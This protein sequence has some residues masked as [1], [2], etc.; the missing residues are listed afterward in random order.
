MGWIIS[1]IILAIIA[2]PILYYLWRH[3][4]AQKPW[5]PIYALAGFILF[6]VLFYAFGL[7]PDNHPTDLDVEAFAEL[8]VQY[9]GRLMPVDTAA[10][11]SLRLL[12]GR[13][14]VE[15]PS[16]E[17]L[18]AIDWLLWTM[19]RPADAAELRVFR[20]DHPEVKSLFDLSE[21]RKYFSYAELVPGLEGIDKVI[22]ELPPD[23]ND[24]S[25]YQQQLVKT[26][27]AIELYNNLSSSFHPGINR[28]DIN[29]IDLVKLYQN[30]DDVLRVAARVLSA[31]NSGE[32]P[33]PRD[34]RFLQILRS[35]VPVFQVMASPRERIA[36]V[37]PADPEADLDHGTYSDAP[38]QTMGA[39]LLEAAQTARTH[40]TVSDYADLIL[41]YRDS[42]PEAFRASVESI[43]TTT[44]DFVSTRRIALEEGFNRSAPFFSGSIIYLACLL[45]IFASWLSIN[46]KAGLPEALRQTAFFLLIGGFLLHSGG[47]MARMIIMERPAPVT[48]LYSSAV[49][50]GWAACGLGLLLEQIYRNSFGVLIAGV[51]GFCTLIIAH[52]LGGS[53][54]TMEAMRAV[55]DSNFWLAT[56]V[57][58]ITLGYTPM[59]IAALLA[60]VF[61]LRG[62]FTRGFSAAA[63]RSIIQ[64]I[65]GTIGFALI[66]SFIGTF[67]GGVWADQSWGRFW[68][69]DPKENGALMI[70]LWAALILHA[71]I[72]GVARERGLMVLTLFG[73]MITAW[74][75]F[76]TNQLGIGLHSYGFT[77]AGHFWLLVFWGS[78]LLLIGLALVPVR[79][80][81]SQ[82]IFN[83]S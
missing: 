41:A 83:H 62:L 20:I 11:T 14:T 19:A 32:S 49:F 30:W 17:R 55:L 37:P 64:M 43:Q 54:D 42:D 33:D 79:F 21:E 16:G 58:T 46:E 13:E 59:F 80:W 51:V 10:R 57:V 44:S 12:R 26:L 1:Y 34:A 36:V 65:Y 61:I 70:V 27:T 60:I 45:L 71:R 5:R 35:V 23:P 66:L 18:F 4:V 82:Q 68:G 3:P 72:A 76:G 15:A 73:S 63:S 2:L 69:W 67:L 25:V 39:A 40:P 6:G 81:R 48:N 47:L 52:G 31:S 78:Q 24:Y 56:H 53:G 22:G 50:I 28:P 74:S 7:K 38:W 75:W 8:P 9:E 29:P 77:D